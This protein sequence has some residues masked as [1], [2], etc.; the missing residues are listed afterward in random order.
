M[1]EQALGP[2][3]HVGV[4]VKD[5]DAAA[6]QFQAL[7]GAVLKSGIIDDANQQVRLRFVEIGGLRIELLEPAADPSPLD[8]L[9]KRGIAIYHICHEVDDLDAALARLTASG[10]KV[11]SP[12]RPAIAF[13]NRRVA[14]VMCQGLMIELLESK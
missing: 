9:I 2:F 4:A 10:A 13:D 8:S 1:P 11:V 3:H 6:A 7:F 14:F 12:P 5:V